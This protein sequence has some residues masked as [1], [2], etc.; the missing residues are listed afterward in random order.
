MFAAINLEAEVYL[1]DT[2][3]ENCPAPTQAVTLIVRQGIEVLLKDEEG[4]PTATVFVE[5]REGQVL[6]SVWDLF[7]DLCNEPVVHLLKDVNVKAPGAR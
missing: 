1:I 3:S 5:L 6:A 4:H 7:S 2:D